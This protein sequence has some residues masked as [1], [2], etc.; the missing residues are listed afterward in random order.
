MEASRGRGGLSQTWGET[1]IWELEGK[2]GSEPWHSHWAMASTYCRGTAMPTIQVRPLGPKS[3]PS[4]S[5][6]ALQLTN[7]IWRC[8]GSVSGAVS[9]DCDPKSDERPPPSTYTLD[10]SLLRRA[11]W[12]NPSAASCTHS[13]SGTSLE[14]REGSTRGGV[15]YSRGL[16][17]EKC[18]G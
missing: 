16:T 10:Q 14:E 4:A 3:P 1:R 11:I 12:K 5:S 6:P 13:A 2:A 8:W 17:G 18:P 15:T 7:S 9:C